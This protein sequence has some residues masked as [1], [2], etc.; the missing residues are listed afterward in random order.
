MDENRIKQAERNFNNYLRDR[1]I[2]KVKFESLIYNTFIRNAKE[3]L[4][5]A[6]QLFENKTSS[7]WVVVTSYYSMFYIACAYLYKLGYKASGEISHQVINETLIVQA[8]N[9][10]KN[11]LLENYENEK[12]KAL[13]I[14]D[15]HLDNYEREKSK[16]ASFQYETTEEIKEGK[17]KTSLERAKEFFEL[18]RE[19]LIK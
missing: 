3:S 19:I 10:I 16:R 5:V 9:K 12:D 17:A 8:R 2:K 7:L 15:T 1:L 14:V 11:Y 13:S 18:I 6:N 4:N